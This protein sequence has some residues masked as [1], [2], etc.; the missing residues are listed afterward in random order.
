MKK[1]IIAV[2]LD[3]V[4]AAQNE[5]MREFANKHYGLT[6]TPQDYKI[7]APYWGF[8]DAVWGVDSQEARQ[9]INEFHNSGAL[10]LQRLIPD[11]I[12][13]IERLK[14]KYELVIITSRHNKHTAETRYWLDKHFP[15]VF[16]NIHFVNVWSDD[17]KETKAM[18][19]KRIGANYLIDDNLEHCSLAAEEGIT[20]L[21]FGEYGWNKSKKLPKGVVR[22][23]NWAEVGSYFDDQANYSS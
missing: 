22:A 18:I 23:K 9:R 10:S 7:E 2:D 11:S 8:W 14:K 13:S 1:Q 21:L 17:I 6:H 16:S 4:L 20:S 12:E 15:K 19:C 3:D 5:A